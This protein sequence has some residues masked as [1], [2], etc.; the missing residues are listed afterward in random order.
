MQSPLNSDMGSA[1]PGKAWTSASDWQVL[2]S[3]Y[4]PFIGYGA[5]RAAAWVLPR[6]GDRRA[7]VTR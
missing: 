2:L 7:A 1:T 6:Y 4:A 3:A 5:A